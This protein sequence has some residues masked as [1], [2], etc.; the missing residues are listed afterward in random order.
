M[1]LNHSFVSLTLSN[2][3]TG[4][5]SIICPDYEFN[6]YLRLFYISY[7]MEC[8]HYES[9][10]GW[11]EIKA[12]QG[13]I[14]SLTVVSKPEAPLNSQ[15]KTI[16]QCCVELTEYFA[17][18]RKEFRVNVAPQGTVFQQKVWELL[19]H[20]PYG[21]TISYADLARQTGNTK[22]SRAVGSANGKNPIAIII[23]CH[24]VIN[25]NGDL[26]GY[27]YGLE[28]KRALLKLEKYERKGDHTLRLD[29]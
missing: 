7:V 26:G 24:R 1:H 3:Q 15:D 29:F 14:V 12:D 28:V 22:A 17:G 25:A 4:S 5:L 11:L 20:I 23:P 10:V 9:P 27:A 2:S 21:K 13:A 19:Q 18:Q 6:N 16:L 8:H